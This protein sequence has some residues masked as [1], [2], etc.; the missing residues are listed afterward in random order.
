[1]NTFTKLKPLAQ[2][3]AHR[4]TAIAVAIA[5]FAAVSA[6]ALSGAEE[7]TA[8]APAPMASISVSVVTPAPARFERALAATGSIR[9]R[10]ELIVGSDTGGVRLL[11][12][13]A[14][15]G[16]IVRKGEL[17]ARADDAQLRAQL[18]GQRAQVKQATGQL[19]QARAN[20]ARATELKEA[21][22]YSDEVYEARQ[23]EAIVAEATLELAEAKLREL[24]VMVARTRIVAPADGVVSSKTATVGAVI[25][26]GA[27]LFRVI[28]DGSLEWLAELPSQ[29]LA[30]VGPGDAARVQLDD[31]RSVE[32]RVRLVEPSMNSNTRNGL[33][34]VSL[35]QGTGVVAGSHARG[36]ILLGSVQALAVPESSVFTRDGYSF[37]Y[38]LDA[39]GVARR[40]KVVTGARSGSLVE[41]S[42]GIDAQTRV[43]GT[44]AGFVKDGE[45]VQVTQRVASAGEAS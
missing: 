37:V 8:A 25:Q 29:S 26:P 20:A 39:D 5:G 35:P 9:A 19:A 30:Q 2:R 6:M 10:D 16:S 41:V 24:E 17:L 44:G 36:Q 14:D 7:A 21:G 43:V 34:H 38:A 40:V 28:K 1:M 27:E 45:R 15:V 4:R 12:V 31:G 3:F 22:V 18:A 13:R 32:A 42:A 11:E 23:T 33:V